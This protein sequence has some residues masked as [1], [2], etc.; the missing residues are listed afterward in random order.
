MYLILQQQKADDY[1]IATG[2]SISV[3]QFISL[4]CNFV[5]IE[6]DFKNKGVDEIGYIK[7]LDNDKFYK[8]VGTKNNLLKVG[9]E[10]IRVDPF[11]YRPTEV[12]ELIGDFSKAKKILGWEPTFTVKALAEDMMK[13]DIKLMKRESLLKS[14]GH[15]SF[16]SVEDVL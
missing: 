5:G 15:S 4:C 9:K 11:Y 16:P 3:K 13:S 7:R 6:V 2:K 12:D 8:A 14:E 1:V 10:I